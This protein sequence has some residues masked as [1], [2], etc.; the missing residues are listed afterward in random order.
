MVGPSGYSDLAWVRD[1]RDRRL[2][3]RKEGLGKD[4]D[5]L[6]EQTLN[7]HRSKYLLRDEEAFRNPSWRDRRARSRSSSLPRFSGKRTINIVNRN[8]LPLSYPPVADRFVRIRVESGSGSRCVTTNRSEPGVGPRPTEVPSL[9]PG[10]GHPRFSSTPPTRRLNNSDHRHVHR[11]P[12]LNTRRVFSQ[13]DLASR[14]G[15]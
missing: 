7:L 14:S 3:F 10:S 15:L 12:I 6:R 5:P 9:S 1:R 4:A 2:D 8:L 11:D 13:T